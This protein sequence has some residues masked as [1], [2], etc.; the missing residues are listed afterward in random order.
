MVPSCQ[1]PTGLY[2]SDG[3]CPNGMTEIPWRSGKLLIWN[4]TCSDT[5]APPTLL[6]PPGRQQ[7]CQPWPRRG[8]WTSM[9]HSATPM[10]SLQSPLRLSKSLS[11]TM[12]FLKDLG[13]R[14]ARVTRD[15]NATNY[16]LQGSQWQSSRGMLLLC[17]ASFPICLAQTRLYL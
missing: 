17:W 14:F 1:E 15:V 2:C 11:D 7:Q 3:K 12:T 10:L 6:L 5:F 4:A 8:R 9:S 13:H 16:L